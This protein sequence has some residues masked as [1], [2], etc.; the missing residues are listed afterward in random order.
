MHNLHIPFYFKIMSEIKIYQASDSQIEVSVQFDKDTVWLNRNQIA[1][2]YGRDVKTVG[3]HIGNVFNEKELS[4]EA[5][6]AKFAT[7]Q[8][9][10]DREVNRDVEYYNL[11]VIISVGYRV[12]SQQG[13]RFRIWATQQ[14]K[15]YLVQ[16]YAINEKRLAQKQQ[17]V[18]SLKTG[19][20]I[21]NRAIEEKAA[22]LAALTLFIATSKTEEAEIVKQLTISI[23]NRNK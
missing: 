8:R 22:T 21:L 9:E 13:N 7:V 2:L 15:D 16:G 10:G 18:E 5:T 19:I 6:V 11:D 23:L 1:I 20:R 14:L 3:K 4:K 12:K 17:E